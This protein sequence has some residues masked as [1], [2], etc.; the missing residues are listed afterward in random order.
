M[1]S[2]KKVILDKKDGH[3]AL[4]TDTTPSDI[5]VMFS[6]DGFYINLKKY[7][8]GVA[9][10]IIQSIIKRIITHTDMGKQDDCIPYK[11]KIVKNNDSFRTLSLPHPKSQI[12]MC[13]IYNEHSDI[14]C[15]LCSESTFSIRH[16]LK[17]GS[18][19]YK[20]ESSQKK[21]LKGAGI[22]TI[23]QEM[24]YKHASSYY[25]YGG[26]D[27][28][29]KFF[30]SPDYLY[31]ESKF[32]YLL[33]TD[34]SHCFSSI[35]THSISWAIKN[36]KYIKSNLMDHSKNFQFGEK[37]DLTIRKS[38]E[39]ETNSI[40]IG[41]ESSRVFAEIILQDADKEIKRKLSEQGINQGTDYEIRRYVDD[42]FVFTT[43]KEKGDS[44]LSAIED[45]LAPYNLHINNKKTQSYER[46]FSTEISEAILKCKT[47]IESTD[48]KISSRV[49]GAKTY[50]RIHRQHSFVKTFI[51]NIKSI[52]SSSEMGYALIASYIISALSK[53]LTFA[54]Y[55]LINSNE[56][57]KTDIKTHIS[58][59]TRILIFLFGVSPNV[60]SSERI[61]KSFLITNSRIKKHLPNYL[62]EWQMLTSTLITNILPPQKTPPH[63]E[64]FVFLEKI[65]L[66]LSMSDFEPAL[67]IGK[68]QVQEFIQ[69][70]NSYFGLVSALYYIKDN[71]KY[72]DERIAIEG[73]IK[74]NLLPINDNIS[75]NSENCHLFLDMICCPYISIETKSELLKSY[76]A[77]YEPSETGRAAKNI[78]ESISDIYWF[79]K[80]NNLNLVKLLERKEL[81]PAY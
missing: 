72:N 16:P 49:D 11:Y 25:S 45:S 75:K 14:I 62:L 21:T 30:E 69:N 64:N 19:F 18:S 73:I 58:S 42:F 68:N 37:F 20:D 53:K 59:F 46:P 9:P 34:I 13:E 32:S 3:R 48:E 23:E 79:V 54:S 2:R 4:L 81:M 5:P 67:L 10:F 38:N 36:K 61:A 50:K 27:R 55:N 56:E 57:Q 29:H 6:N 40:P 33:I 31:L 52:C 12:S 8:E 80:W 39:N 15:H 76:L 51:D 22:D 60:G 78:I 17:V 63:T 26:F 71:D 28:P 66:Y 70:N 24:N 65:N 1:T 7:E 43:D 35:Y 77:Y 44:V 47:L 74:R 41:P